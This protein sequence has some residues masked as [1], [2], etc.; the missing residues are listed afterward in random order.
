MRK[1]R[2]LR[3]AVALSVLMGVGLA[4]SAPKANAAQS[5]RRCALA[6]Q[7]LADY[8]AAG[9]SD[10]AIIAYLQQLVTLACS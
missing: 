3:S 10:P 4:I 5:P 2:R 1:F 9:G 8:Q 7:L 6:Q